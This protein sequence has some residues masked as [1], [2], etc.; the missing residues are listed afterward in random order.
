MQLPG[1]PSCLLEALQQAA[2]GQRL[3]LVGGAVRDLLLHRRHCDPWR[4]LP[5]LDVVIE[6]RA[7][8]LVSGFSLSASARPH[9]AFGTVELEVRLPDHSDPWLLD[10]ASARREIYPSPGANPQVLP[11]SLEDD[12][13][14]R[15]FSVNAMALLLGE[16]A[17][18]LDPYGG[19]ADLASRTLRFLHS[20]SV[21][22]DPT[23]LVRAA[24]YSARL[25]FA[26]DEASRRQAIETLDAW[27][28][29]WQIG[30]PPSLAPPSLSTRLRMELE[31]LFV[32]EPWGRALTA[33]QDWRCLRLLDCQLQ[34]DPF[35]F[36]RL[37]WAQRLGLPLLPA[38]LAGAS[39]PTSL[40]VRLQLPH[41]YVRLLS[42]MEELR[43]RLTECRPETPSGWSALLEAPGLTPDAVALAVVTGARPRG[44]L[45][46]WWLRW[47]HL[48]APLT[49][50]ALM[51][52]EGLKPGPEVGL[53]LRQLRAERLD[54]ER[55]RRD[56]LAS[57]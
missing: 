49:A 36:R 8:D 9:G 57:S 40:A 43:T 38:F 41:R 26:L 17:R 7:E 34:S 15:D 12:L 55:L 45:L 47:R 10:L 52:Q 37:R 54:R 32:R 1:V 6:G 29:S 48:K 31:L 42:Q 24:R 13:A 44:P 30:D 19:Q 27:P 20:R 53:R 11:G 5:D 46:R 28:W 35:W 25:G 50:A 22:D 16:E 21:E 3:A 39:T 14:R 18:I 23:R 33:L 51:A 4:G 56:R 2:A